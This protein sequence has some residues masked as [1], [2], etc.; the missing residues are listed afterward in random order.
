M[1]DFINIINEPNDIN[2]DAILVKLD[3]KSLYTN[4]PNYEGIVAV[5]STLNSLYQKPVVTK[6]ISKF[7]FLI[8]TLNNFVFSGI[9]NLQKL[10]CTMGTKRASNYANIFMGR[11]EKTYIYRYINLFSNFSRQFIDDIF[12]LWNGTVI[13]H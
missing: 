10:G 4:I 2:K 7:L 1:S 9:H 6:N 5:K 3:V 11:S 13:I 12:F 8:L